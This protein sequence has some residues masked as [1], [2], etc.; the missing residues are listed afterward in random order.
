LQQRNLLTNRVRRS[1]RGVS[2][3]YIQKGEC[4]A[5]VHTKGFMLQSSAEEYAGQLPMGTDTHPSKPNQ[6][7]ISVV[8]E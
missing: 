3:A 7:E 6:P 4:Y 5:G 8:V 2:Y 1:G